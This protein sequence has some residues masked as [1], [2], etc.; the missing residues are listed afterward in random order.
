[1]RGGMR[2]MRDDGIEKV[3]QGLT[4]LVEVGRVTSM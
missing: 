4:S 2:T 3:K 1:M